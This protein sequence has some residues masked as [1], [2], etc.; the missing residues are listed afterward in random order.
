MTDRAG[1]L[2]AGRPSAARAEHRRAHGRSASAPL[3][4]VLAIVLGGSWAVT[5]RGA[6][7][8]PGEGPS[9]GPGRS[10]RALRRDFLLVARAEGRRR[11]EPGRC[12]F[13]PFPGGPAA[14][15]E[16]HAPRRRGGW[17]A[18]SPGR[19]FPAAFRWGRD[20]HA[21]LRLRCA[22][23]C[24]E[25]EGTRP[26]LLSRVSPLSAFAE[27]HDEPA[28]T[29]RDRATGHLSAEGLPET[30]WGGPFEHY[31]QSKCHLQP[32]CKTLMIW[33]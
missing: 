5:L 26:L 28:R 22:R 27:P 12:P 9:S 24:A 6:Q 10:L 29:V 15:T 30:P 14:G 20:R 4:G 3:G 13:R 7:R 16:A 31:I 17:A 33:P 11:D 18:A 32:R 25:R 23:A 8:S 19:A 2:P 1:G 21:S